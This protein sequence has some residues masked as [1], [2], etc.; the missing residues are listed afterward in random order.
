[1]D[2]KKTDKR[3][4]ESF[5]HTELYETSKLPHTKDTAK[6]E[7][8]MVFALN[9]QKTVGFL[10]NEVDNISVN[11]SLSFL[12][13]PPHLSNLKTINHNVWELYLN[14]ESKQKAFRSG[15][16]LNPSIFGLGIG[17]I[18]MDVLVREGKTLLG[19]SSSNLTIMK[20]NEDM[21]QIKNTFYARFGIDTDSVD[22]SPGSSGDIVIEYFYDLNGLKADDVGH[23]K[24]LDVS[25]YI[26]ASLKKIEIQQTKIDNE[27]NQEGYGFCGK[28]LVMLAICTIFMCVGAFLWLR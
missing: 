12:K 14:R 9:I 19:G 20:E 11:V 16:F 3:S 25:N 10:N 27:E 24:Q 7:G 6:I 8:T 17:S 22:N 28:A 13:T 2:T 4:E 18:M 26:A 21:T 1:M 5:F 15:L 23:I